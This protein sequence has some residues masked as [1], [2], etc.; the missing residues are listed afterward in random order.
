MINLQ[1]DLWQ[2]Y[3]LTYDK[4]KVLAYNKT[5]VWV[6]KKLHIDK[7][8]VLP[9]KNTNIHLWQ[10]YSLTCDKFTYWAVTKKHIDLWQNHYNKI[11]PAAS[12][13][14]VAQVVSAVGLTHW[15]KSWGFESHSSWI[16][17]GKD[18]KFNFVIKVGLWLRFCNL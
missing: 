17:L 14:S 18:F 7:S 5:A 15:H 4:N 2:N 16:F 10:I 6:L 11:C 1:L 3:S 9:M 12:T 8:T 13:S